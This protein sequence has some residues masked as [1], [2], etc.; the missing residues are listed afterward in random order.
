MFVVRVT[1][2]LLFVPPLSGLPVQFTP[3]PNDGGA[4]PY[5]YDVLVA[6][7]TFTAGLPTSERSA[8]VAL[9]TLSSSAV[10]R[11]NASSALRVQTPLPAAILAGG[12][13]NVTAVV[14]ARNFVSTSNYS[15]VM[16][17]DSCSNHSCVNNGTCVNVPYSPFQIRS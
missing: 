13:R 14:R 9:F 7:S 4:A 8:H 2:V 3:I 15:N 5:E 16:G 12:G 1:S 10:T 6:D 17:A 11:L